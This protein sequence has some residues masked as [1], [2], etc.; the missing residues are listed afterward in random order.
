MTTTKDADEQ[1]PTTLVMGRVRVEPRRARLPCLVAVS[2]IQAGRLIAIRRNEGPLIL[3]RGGEADIRVDRPEISRRHARLEYDGERLRLTD[4]RSANGTFVNEQP[5][6]HVV[7]KA[8]DK[9]RLG[10]QVIF[11]L[12]FL[13]DEEIRLT[14]D[15]HRRAIRDSLT[16]VINRDFFMA[17]LQREWSYVRRHPQWISLLMLDLDHFKSINDSYGH[18]TGDQVLRLFAE[19]AQQ[20]T[21]LEDVLARYGGEEFVMLLRDTDCRGARVVA[22]RVRRMV[23]VTPFRVSGESIRLT[24]SIGVSC[25]GPD[26]LPDRKLDD[27]LQIADSRLYDAK[28]GGRNR[29]CG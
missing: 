19:L 24:V 5:I 22:E 7:L 12:S 11:R 20:V 8:D 15:L 23:A 25:L 29:V 18:R 3:G 2:G 21:R 9:V 16:G 13:S 1:G 4:L 27:L 17:T 10:P 6:E 14:Q 28:T 26:E